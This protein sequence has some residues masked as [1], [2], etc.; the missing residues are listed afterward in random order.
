[1]R[2]KTA[3][4]F[5]VPLALF[6]VA[7]GRLN[8]G[9]SNGASGGDTIDHPT[10]ATDLLL[11]VEFE[12]GFIP[13]EYNLSRLPSWSLY[14]D[15]RIVTEGPQIE[16]YPAPA[17]PNLLVRPVNEDAIQAILRAAR[18]AGL[19]DGDAEYDYP[20]VTDV[21]TTVF[22]VTAGGATSVVSAYA[23]G[24]DQAPC[25]DADIEARAELASFQ[26]KLGDLGRWLPEGS[27][28]TEEPFTPSAVRLFVRPYTGSPD[29]ELEQEP[30][31]WPFPGSLRKI[32]EPVKALD[33]YRCIALDGADASTFLAAA[34][35]ANQLTPWRSEGER[36]SIVVRPLLP[37]ESGC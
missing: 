29:P 10:G 14:G 11:R 22:T 7:C 31:D 8:D 24:M 15:G 6:A 19:M 34:A 23:L 25:M 1:M 5:L 13:V 35:D 30:K 4:A 32:G 17:L 20:C 18:D 21:P 9:G 33:A 36:Y 12:G 3:A 27:V 26:T 16:I 28:G 2:T 37:D